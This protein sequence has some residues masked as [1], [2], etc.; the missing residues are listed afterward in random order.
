MHFLLVAEP[1]GHIWRRE[2]AGLALLYSF[3]SSSPSLLVSNL[4]MLPRRPTSVDA[5]IPSLLLGKF[6]VNGPNL[7]LHVETLHVVHLGLAFALCISIKTLNGGLFPPRKFIFA[8]CLAGYR[9]ED[10]AALARQSLQVVGHVGVR[11]R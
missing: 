10:V 3:P 1:Q 8:D 5:P 6:L 11:N 2:E 4:L 7:L 9:V